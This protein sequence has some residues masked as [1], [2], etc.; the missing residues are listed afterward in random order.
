MEGLKNEYTVDEIHKAL[1]EKFKDNSSQALLLHTLLLSKN[2]RDLIKNLSI[3]TL[4][5]APSGSNLEPHWH[6]ILPKAWGKAHGYESYD[7][8][9]NVTRICGESNMKGPLKNKPPWEYVPEMQ[10][11]E[12]AL[13]D[14]F[15]PEAY[16]HK[17]FCG[18]SLSPTEY[19]NFL[20]EREGLI[21]N[22]AVG[23]LRI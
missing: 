14:H 7:T 20:N 12:Q 21:T 19:K 15:V 8:V 9:A 6:H 1:A 10:I 17:F 11:T 22:E 23:V 4:T 18:Q 16:A 13:V 2:A 5:L 3:R